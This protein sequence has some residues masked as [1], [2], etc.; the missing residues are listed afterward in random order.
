MLKAT[1]INPLT[2]TGTFGKTRN[3]ATKDDRSCL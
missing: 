2:L 1:V 3:K